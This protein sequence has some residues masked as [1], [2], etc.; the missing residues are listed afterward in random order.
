MTAK[1]FTKAIKGI[2]LITAGVFSFSFSANSQTLFNNGA[3]IYINTDTVMFVDGDVHNYQGTIV[4]LGRFDI[5]GDMINDAQ[6]GG[7]GSPLPP[8][9][10]LP[11]CNG[12]F[13]VQGDWRNNNEFNAGT[14]KVLLYG[15]LQLITGSQSSYFY[16]LE[17]TGTN[18]K[19][20]QGVDQYST[21]TLALNDRELW[22]DKYTMYV[23]N[24]N[25]SAITR[26]TGFVSSLESGSLSRRMLSASDYLFPVGSLQGFP[27]G[28][29]PA[30]IRPNTT[31]PNRFTVRLVNFDPI[32]D[33]PDD[34]NDYTK[35]TS[36]HD[37]TVC[38]VNDNYWYKINHPEGTDNADLALSYDAA[39]TD[40]QGAY[41]GIVQWDNVNDNQWESLGVPTSN[42]LSN[43]PNDP[44]TLTFVRRN[45]VTNFSPEP[46]TLAYLIPPPPPLFGI[47]V[48]CADVQ[49]TYSVIPNTNGSY[50]FYVD[51]VGG[52][53]TGQIISTTDTSATVIWNDMNWGNVYVIETIDNQ[54]GY[55]ACP[56][57]IGNFLV[58]IL[59]LP[60][61]GFE[62]TNEYN[63]P[64]PNGT[65]NYNNPDDVFIN[66][67]ISF[68]DTSTNTVSWAWDFN[69]GVNSVNQN[70]Y[71]TYGGLGTYN[72][73][74]V[75]TSPD[76]CL[77]T[78]YQ[79]I[80]V[81][82]GLIVPNVFTPD[83]D[84]YND[85]FKIRNSNVS[86]F[87]FRVFNR[88]GTQ[89]YETTAP[90][91][92]WDGKTQAGSEA[93]AGTYFYTLDAK[94]ASGNDI[95]IFQDK[96]TLEKGTITLIR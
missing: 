71:H 93:P 76:G 51:T 70:P 25:A 19:E 16:D 15:D 90:E 86:E 57:L 87:T 66:D 74:M 84:G 61:A 42:S 53:A 20:I 82:E 21:G 52:V 64:N 32:T 11:E 78:A 62:T 30:V 89:I 63:N 4:N 22:T 88:W 39:V 77:D 85:V 79:A 95:A 8:N 33:D 81:I 91:I 10:G 56:S 54:N 73:M 5:T 58:D 36:D 60:H 47:D 75:A 67:L 7:T 18:R 69:D 29:R 6:L 41:N 49:T 28:Y 96:D 38:Y 43:D 12:I 26:S 72:V 44:A 2:S 55:V 34:L 17:L 40:D 65:Y 50:Y 31:F 68:H 37:T 14:G 48:I 23:E 80:N 92:A 35:P 45:G 1:S 59:S 27:R 83:G 3:M 24:T 13:R 94:L 9:N 46:F